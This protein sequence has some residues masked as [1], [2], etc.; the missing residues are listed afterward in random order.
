MKECFTAKN[1]TDL[2]QVCHQMYDSPF[3]QTLELGIF[4]NTAGNIFHILQYLATKLHYFSKFR[5]LFPAVL[6]KIPNS[7]VFLKG[8]WSIVPGLLA[9]SSYIESV[10]IRPTSY[11]DSFFGKK[12]SC[13]IAGQLNTGLA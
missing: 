11:P 8:E 1:T 10:R 9:L 2:T 4:I 13:P 12:A 6:M 7:K 3:R 5:M